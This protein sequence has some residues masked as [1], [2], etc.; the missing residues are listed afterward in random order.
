MFKAFFTIAI[1]ICA[2]SA[3]IVKAQN[4]NP[5]PVWQAQWIESGSVEDKALRPAQYFRKTF[6]AKQKVKKAVVYITSHGM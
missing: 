5:Q 3:S 2:L 1:T 4:Q 6:D